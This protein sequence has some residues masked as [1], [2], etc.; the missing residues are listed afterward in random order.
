VVVAII[1]ILAA[2][3][4]PALGKARERARRILCLSQFK[5]IGLASTLYADDSEDCLP[6]KE[7]NWAAAHY[8][9]NSYLRKA[10]PWSLWEDKYLTD[11]LLICPNTPAKLDP[12][13]V[14]E[15]VHTTT[16]SSRSMRGGSNENVASG[17]AAKN[18]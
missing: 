16:T 4:L 10:N 17:N 7:G 5:Q 18:A 13:W 3:L 15:I 9:T 12:A 11:E 14:P 6:N 2:L 8:N 1:A